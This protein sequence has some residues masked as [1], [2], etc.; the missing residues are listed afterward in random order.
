MYAAAYR[1]LVIGGC[2]SIKFVLDS[3]VSDN[4]E[5]YECIVFFLPVILYVLNCSGFGGSA[6]KCVQDMLGRWVGLL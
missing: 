2:R 3:F 1:L 6:K 4:G 5:Q